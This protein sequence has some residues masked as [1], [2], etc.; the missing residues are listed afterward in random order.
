M[1]NN[2][3]AIDV[4]TAQGKRWSLCQI[5][6]IDVKNGQIKNKYSFLVK[7]PGNK[8]SGF[9]TRIH[10]ISSE[11]TEDEPYF[12]EI[13]RK[14]YPLL[15]N[16]LLI[17][18][19]ASFDIDVLKKTLAY[20]SIEIPYFNYACTYKLS[21]QSLDKACSS[22]NINLTNHHDALADAEA[23]AKLYL[24]LINGAEPNNVVGTSKK[25]AQIYENLQGDVLKPNLSNA[26]P[27]SP[28]YDKK[29][30]FT[31]TLSTIKR[32]K[33]AIITKNMGGDID[34]SVTKRTNYIIAG[35]KPGPSKIK[36]AQKYISEG[37]EIKI[38]CEEEF[39]RL[40]NHK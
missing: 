26:D 40:I 16:K 6:L 39:L 13:W 17:A 22:Y 2:F 24:K 21:G 35:D 15:K 18:H 10:G 29:V 19:N 32:S 5:G 31:G 36:K 11:I 14:I 20:Y 9:N 3:I 12:P 7:P 23:A 30:V 27:S 38:L 28:F 1:D 4:E 25:K 34:T 33:A 8:Y 37:Y